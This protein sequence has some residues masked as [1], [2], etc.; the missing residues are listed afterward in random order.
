MRPHQNRRWIAPYLRMSVRRPRQL[1]EAV[2]PS[3]SKA[4]W[5]TLYNSIAALCVELSSAGVAF[6]SQGPGAG[7]GTATRFTQLAMAVAV[8]GAVAVV[9]GLGLIGAIR[10]R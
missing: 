10:R 8:Y 3:F 4:H 9:I 6:A 7:P 5:R 2:M 1:Q